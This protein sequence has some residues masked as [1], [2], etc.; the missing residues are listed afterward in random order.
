[1]RREGDAPTE[2]TDDVVD[3]LFA[4]M[5][6]SFHGVASERA[7]GGHPVAGPQENRVGGVANVIGPGI[8]ASS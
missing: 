5:T 8:S 6:G 4:S 7:E 3:A 1:M 2:V